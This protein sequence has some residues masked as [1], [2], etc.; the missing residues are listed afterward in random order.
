MAATRKM[1]DCP[2]FGSFS[3]LSG[4][5]LPTYEDMMKCYLYER[6]QMQQLTKKDPAVNDIANIVSKEIV[7]VEKSLNPMCFS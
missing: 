2:I 6:H 1:I 7:S 4:R 3:D 5:M